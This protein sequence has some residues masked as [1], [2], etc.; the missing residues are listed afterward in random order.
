MK[1]SEIKEIGCYVDDDYHEMLRA[2]TALRG[3]SIL[4]VET[5]N[6]F[7]ELLEL[8]LELLNKALE[9]MIVVQP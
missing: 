9:N 8:P 6:P 3:L 4:F 5:D 7:T 1:A 2:V